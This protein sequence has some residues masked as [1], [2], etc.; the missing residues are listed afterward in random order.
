MIRIVYLFDD[1]MSIN[2]ISKLLV[3]NYSWTWRVINKLMKDNNLMEEIYKDY[4]DL[5]EDEGIE[6]LKSKF[7][8]E[9]KRRKKEK[10]KKENK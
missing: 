10:E 9:C 2:D 8:K 5:V 6:K 4:E 3:S 1:S 7:K